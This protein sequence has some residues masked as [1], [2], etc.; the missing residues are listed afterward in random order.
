MT[1]SGR[2]K[3]FILERFLVDMPVPIQGSTR[4][5]CGI[6]LN[7]VERAHGYSDVS[8]HG[9]D[10]CPARSLL[11]ESIDPKVRQQL[12]GYSQVVGEGARRGKFA[13][14]TCPGEDK[15]APVS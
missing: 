5:L 1:I 10:S 6:E 2:L 12:E 14:S 15:K 4:N 7:D 13:R 8:W 11:T 9:R 3:N